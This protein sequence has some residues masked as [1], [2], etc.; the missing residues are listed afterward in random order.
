[1]AADGGNSSTVNGHTVNSNVPANAKFTDT[2][3]WRP[4]PDWNATSGD[5]VIKNKPSLGTAASKNIEDFAVVSIL[6]EAKYN[7][8]SEAEQKNGTIYFTY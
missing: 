6:E 5:A 4:Q 3:T 1:M 8:L 7:A 2:N